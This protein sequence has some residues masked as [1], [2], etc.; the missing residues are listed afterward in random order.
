M[1]VYVISFLSGVAATHVFHKSGLRVPED[2]SIVISDEL[3]LA[4]HV[5]PPLTSVRMPLARMGE[6]A[7]GMLLRAVA[8]EPVADVVL[9][10]PPEL[11]IHASTGPP[12]PSI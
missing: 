7:A 5:A 10:D 3:S 11:V 9:P 6:V 8:G 4:A 1:A 12:P 2:I